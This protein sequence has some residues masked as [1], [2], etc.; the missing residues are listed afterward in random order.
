MS[1]CLLNFVEQVLRHPKLNAAQKNK[2]GKGAE[3]KLKNKTQ[4]KQSENLPRTRQDTHAQRGHVCDRAVCGSTMAGKMGYIRN[5]AATC[6]Q[7]EDNS[8]EKAND[9]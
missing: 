1:F 9:R 3:E 7:I 5:M 6:N 4:A 8:I 2:E